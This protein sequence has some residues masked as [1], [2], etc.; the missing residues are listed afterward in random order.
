MLKNFDHGFFHENHKSNKP[1]CDCPRLGTVF[2]FALFS[3]PILVSLLDRL[4]FTDAKSCLCSFILSLVFDEKAFLQ[5]LATMISFALLLVILAKVQK[6]ATLVG[7][8]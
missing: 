1:D 5:I 6:M 3:G 8:L 7:A 4:R 2:W